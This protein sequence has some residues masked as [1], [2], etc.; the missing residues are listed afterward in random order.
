MKKLAEFLIDAKAGPNGEDLI[1]ING[2]FYKSTKIK[3]FYPGY[4]DFEPVIESENDEGDLIVKLG[5]RRLVST[6]G[7][8]EE[9]TDALPERFW[10]T[11][12][13]K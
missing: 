6:D 7:N 3:R 10:L 4:P 8:V 2:V 13:E 1:H 12:I 5:S 9:I 11:A